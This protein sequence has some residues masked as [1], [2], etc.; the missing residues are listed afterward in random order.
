MRGIEAVQDGDG[1]VT[2]KTMIRSRSFGDP[3]ED[4]ETIRRAVATHAAR[5]AEKLRAEGLV[6]GRVGA[7]CTTKG[8]GDGPHRTGW[9]EGDL[10]C[11]SN[12]TPDLIRA[13]L[14]AL[15]RG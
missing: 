10:V 15:E 3:V 2:R 8:Y 4:L 6:A 13:A 5:A 14:A 7:F 12:R 1:P 11:A 9:V